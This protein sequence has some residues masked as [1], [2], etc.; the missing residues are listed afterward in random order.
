M[1]SDGRDW[2]CRAGELV[3][4]GETYVVQ[5]NDDMAPAL[6]VSWSG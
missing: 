2:G 5:P 1:I 6:S 4:L 3:D